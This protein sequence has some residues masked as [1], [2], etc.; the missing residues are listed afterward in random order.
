MDKATLRPR[1]AVRSS[2]GP[3]DA[4]S[5]STRALAAPDLQLDR[6][7]DGRLWVQTG[8]SARPVRVRRC[9]PWSEPA[10]FLSLC[11]DDDGEVA[12][13][14]DPASLD[15]ASRTALEAVLIEA[16]FV[17]DLLQVF[18]IEEEVELRHWRVRTAQG[19]RS[20]QTRLDD[21]PREL[22]DGTLLIRDVAG[23]LYRLAAS[24]QLDRRSRTLLWS[25]ID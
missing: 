18:E 7:A 9:F 20:F 13:V 24:E 25:F 10:R 11:D 4:L 6:R 5:A 12:F 21:W 3:N 23:D 22:P 8:D 2:D 16:G 15:D 1:P 14:A 19:N 17:F